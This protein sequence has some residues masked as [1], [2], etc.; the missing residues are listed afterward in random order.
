MCNLAL[1]LRLIAADAGTSRPSW[2]SLSEYLNKNDD[3]NRHSNQ[4]EEVELGT[5]KLWLSHFATWLSDDSVHSVSV[6]GVDWYTAHHPI[7]SST[8][9]DRDSILLQHIQGSLGK[10]GV[11]YPA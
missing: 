6:M 1:L 3:A 11:G 8:F 10:L 9:G 4:L 5:C 7:W 2:R